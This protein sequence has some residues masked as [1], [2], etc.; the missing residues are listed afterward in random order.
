[1]TSTWTD[2]FCANIKQQRWEK[3]K[4]RER[5][6]EHF[7]GKIKE[8]SWSLPYEKEMKAKKMSDQKK[9]YTK[10]IIT[11]LMQRLV[12]AVFGL[13][14]FFVFVFFALNRFSFFINLPQKIFFIYHLWLF[15]KKQ[16]FKARKN[17][18][19]KRNESAKKQWFLRFS[20]KKTFFFKFPAFFWSVFFL[21]F[22]KNSYTHFFLLLRNTEK[23]CDSAFLFFWIFFFLKVSDSALFLP[24]F[25]TILFSFL[26]QFL[27]FDFKQKMNQAKCFLFESL[28]Y[29][30]KKCF[31]RSCLQFFSHSPPFFLNNN[32]K[33][34]THC[35]LCL[36]L[37]FVCLK[38]VS[39][40][41]VFRDLYFVEK[42]KRK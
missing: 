14:I 5:E 25:S 3:K 6:T 37:L 39:L 4:E 30:W 28:F 21:L 31:F 8:R 16:T 18:H 24:W 19:G 35:F 22:F 10:K 40:K 32:G 42:T 34:I 17:Q 12:P 23:K 26:L 38:S 36:L 1:M 13:P 2:A 27:S 7:L 33:K 41:K 29:R 9:Y 11:A 20:P 15:L